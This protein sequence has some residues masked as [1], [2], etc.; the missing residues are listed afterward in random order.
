MNKAVAAFDENLRRNPND[1]NSLVN[2]A[3]VMALQGNVGAAIA[4]FQKALQL[5][6]R[7]PDILFNLA[8]AYTT[9]GAIEK[10]INCY[11]EILRLDPDDQQAR[12]NLSR[13]RS[14]SDGQNR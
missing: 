10:A 8:V 2:R 3:S 4:D 6:R 9:S 13:L 12:E 7:N 5:D 11:E 1:L 14:G